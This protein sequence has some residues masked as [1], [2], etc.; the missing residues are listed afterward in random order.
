M[1]KKKG[2]EIKEHASATEIDSVK[3]CVGFFSNS[4][5]ASFKDNQILLKEHLSGVTFSIF[6]NS[7]LSH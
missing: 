1:I 3:K 6:I 7:P 5:F 4:E 2:K